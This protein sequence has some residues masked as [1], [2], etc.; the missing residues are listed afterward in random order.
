MPPRSRNP[1][2]ANSLAASRCSTPLSL[3]LE[4]SDDDDDGDGGGGGG[5]DSSPIISS[6][7]DDNDDNDEVTILDNVSPSSRSNSQVVP[8]RAAPGK[9]PA[10]PTRSNA[11]QNAPPKESR[12]APT[13][14]S[15]RRGRPRKSATSE[16]SAP[17]SAKE[18]NGVVAA[19]EG[20][21]DGDDTSDSPIVSSQDE[22][23]PDAPR[24]RGRTR[25]SE[26]FLPPADVRKRY[27]RKLAA[28][29]SDSS[30]SGPVASS[31]QD[32]GGCGLRSRSAAA[33]PEKSTVT[34]EDSEE[35]SGW[36]TGD[37]DPF[38][39]HEKN[40]RRRQQQQQ[41][42]Q[43]KSTKPKPKLTPYSLARKFISDLDENCPKLRSGAGKPLP[44]PQVQLGEEQQT[45]QL[46][47]QQR[48][49]GR[50]RKSCKWGKYV[51]FRHSSSSSSEKTESDSS[52]YNTRK[53]K[54]S[55]P[56]SDDAAGGPAAKRKVPS[57]RQSCAFP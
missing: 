15:R 53:R 45:S 38:A 50:S 48:R 41:Q 26:K 1:S 34:S 57:L 54:L 13:T 51:P 27:A 33:F 10:K 5:S 32:S 36:A 21:G 37:P 25:K 31:R 47:Q 18:T 2:G 46:Q 52:S 12:E 4:L 44:P 9:L 3:H 49:R 28:D 29:S 11:E 55:E 40:L 7:E 56:A 42:Q 19:G 20:R 16:E 17:E 24:T 30:V 8:R 43:V 23:V 6:D 22:D 14:T 35:S 39:S